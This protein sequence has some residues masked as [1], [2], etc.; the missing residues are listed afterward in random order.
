MAIELT[1]ANA[2]TLS[3]IQAYSSFSLVNIFP[4]IRLIIGAGGIT[5]YNP[6][7]L[8]NTLDLSSPICRKL[9]QLS[10]AGNSNLSI[11]IGG[12]NLVDIEDAGTTNAI[13]FFGGNLSASTINAFFTALPATTKTATIRVVN[14]PGAATC[15]TSIATGKGYTVV[16][17]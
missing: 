5:V 11:I 17:A 3:A 14:N 7:D 8:G 13:N 15:N 12:S 4:N 2:A 1:T 9:R 16:T 10:T 6:T